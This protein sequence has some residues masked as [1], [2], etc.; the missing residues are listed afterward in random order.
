MRPFLARRW[1]LLTLVAGVALAVAF[2]APLEPAARLLPPQIVVSVAL[3]LMAWGLESRSLGRSLLRPVPALWAGTLSYGF[4][5]LLAWLF[6]WVVTLPPDFRV[7]LIL[8]ASVPCTLASAVLWTRLAGGNEATA[9]LT[10][11]LTTAASW[12]ITPL[13]LAPLV[14]GAAIHLD[15]ARMMRDL[16]LFLVVPVALGQSL[17]APPDL[18]RAA[19]RVKPVLAILAQLLILSI[20]LKA[21][22]NVGQQLRTDAPSLTPAPILVVAAGC[23]GT[24]LAT[25]GTG[26]ASSRALGFDRPSGVAVAFASSQKTLPVALL[27]FE[28]YFKQDYPLAVLPLVF[29]HVGQL[30]VDTTIAD[31]LRCRQSCTEPEKP[32]P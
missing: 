23:L 24:H 10:V 19:Q 20:I 29:Y 1:F 9:L 8:I 28:S 17:R 25:L 3:L 6:A 18:A 27:L 31:Q 30:I 22:V 12:L 11:L 32:T 7:G 4:L 26:L 15:T 2:P 5:P 13:W 21:A 16:V 14:G